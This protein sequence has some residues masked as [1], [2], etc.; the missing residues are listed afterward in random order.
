VLLGI[1]A[2]LADGVS[3][4]ARFAQAD[5]DFAGLVA[6]DNEGAK[7]ETATALHNFGGTIDEDDFLGQAAVILVTE[8]VITT[9]RTASA[10]TAALAA[11]ATAA[12]A[13][14]AATATKS[15]ATAT[16]AALL[17]RLILRRCFESDRFDRRAL[18]RLVGFFSHDIFS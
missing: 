3:D 11:P 15:A 4:F 9:A 17:R 8:I 16:A 1:F 6:D 12:T 10:L 2:A 18:L 13:A 7:A 14:E 5:A